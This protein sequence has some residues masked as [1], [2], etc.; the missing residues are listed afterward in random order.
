MIKVFIGGS[1][2][3]SRLNKD[4]LDRIDNIIANSFTILIGDANGAD[5]SVQKHCAGM[6]YKNVI[7]FCSGNECRNNIGNWRTFNINMEKKRRDINY[8]TVKDLEMAKEADYGFMIWDAKSK[9]TLNNIIELTKL[10]KKVLVYVQPVK[11]FYKISTVGDMKE[12]FNNCDKNSREEF[13]KKLQPSMKIGE[14]YLINN[15]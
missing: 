4:I 13:E 7:V 14:Q 9:G 8:Y 1:R 3:L 15:I 2:R 5:K 11:K 12:L 10:S 6:N